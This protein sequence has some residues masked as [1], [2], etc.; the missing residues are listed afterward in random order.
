M[1]EKLHVVTFREIR[2]VVP[3][4]AFLAVERSDGND[5]GHLQHVAQFDDL[6]QFRVE[7]L[8]FIRH[9]AFLVTFPQASDGGHAF[10][11]AIFVAE[12]A[13]FFH[14]H[15]FH[16]I[17]DIVVTLRSLTLKNSFDR[18]Q[19]AGFFLPFVDRSESD[20]FCILHGRLP[21]AFSEHGSVE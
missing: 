11:Q 16:F 19:H 10:L 5:F 6:I 13:A 20:V 14:H 1:F 17:A 15:F 18:L 8:S 3:A 12:H 21:G 4:A 2:A 9:P 7:Q